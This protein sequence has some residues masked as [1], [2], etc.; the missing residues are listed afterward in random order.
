MFQ[1]NCCDFFLTSGKSMNPII[2]DKSVVLINKL[3]YKFRKPKRGEVII[4]TSTVN[5]DYC[6]CK[7][8]LYVEGDVFEKNGKTIK[9]PKNY[10]WVEGDNKENSFDSRMFGPVNLFLLQGKV[11]YCVYPKIFGF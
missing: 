11:S 6:M 5:S 9:I 3:T 7:R 1:E 2:K 4:F 10:I 8:V